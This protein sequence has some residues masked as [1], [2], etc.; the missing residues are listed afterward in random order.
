MKHE[1]PKAESSIKSTISEIKKAEERK[2]VED[3]VV[4]IKKKTVAEAI[5]NEMLGCNENEIKS[6]VEELEINPEEKERKEAKKRLIEYSKE[7]YKTGKN[8]EMVYSHFEPKGAEGRNFDQEI[9]LFLEKRKED[10]DYNPT[11]TYPEMDKVDIQKLKEDIAD[12]KIIERNVENEA[13]ESVKNIVLE[14]ISVVKAKINI[15]VEIKKGNIEKAFENAK[16]AYGDINDQLYKK[17]KKCHEEKIEFLKEK[18]EKGVVKN[19][20]EKAL[21]ESKFNAEDIKK[22]FDLAL[23]KGDL[24][25]NNLEVVIDEGVTAIDVRPSDPNYDHPVVLIPP[26]REVNGIELIRFVAHEIGCH[27]VQNN[28][29]HKLGLEGLSFGKDW[30]TAQEGFAMRNE[31]K[32]KKEV[33]GESYSDFKVRA[34]PYYILAMEK[35]KESA[36]VGE[37]YDYVFDLMKEEFLAKGDDEEK[38]E[39]K[40]YEKTK[41]ILRRTIRGMRPYYFPKDKAYFEGEFVASEI[42][43]EGVDKYLRQSRVDPALIP[44]MIKAGIYSGSYTYKKGLEVATNIAKQIWED[45]KFMNKNIIKSKSEK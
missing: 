33:L 20:L 43:K 8:Y 34:I 32:I 40:A 5:K 23:D 35:I 2:E 11:F 31:A 19:D 18:K 28:Y 36:N 22:Y 44:D 26:D 29:N 9:D 6:T 16:I 24:R 30:E 12:L 45:K 14:I 13:N 39:E 37:V 27:V 17:A 1:E 15:L 21:E 3:E 10:N 41:K 25:Y 7:I 38:S 42:E 4:E